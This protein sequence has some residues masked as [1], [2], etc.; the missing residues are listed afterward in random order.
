MKKL[1]IILLITFS[2]C[3]S[4][5]RDQIKLEK[6]NQRHPEVIAEKCSEIYIPIDSIIETIR[7][8]PGE[9]VYIDNFAEVNCDSMIKY[10]KDTNVTKKVKVKCPP[11]TI[12]R[13]SVFT[14]T[15]T[16]K[17][18]KAAIFL[19]QKSKDSLTKVSIEQKQ[20][21]K[22]KNKYLAILGSIFGLLILWT[23]FRNY[24]KTTLHI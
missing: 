22:V 9:T 13:D 8:V 3:I 19:L 4:L 5:R 20:K 15:E 6:I 18:N 10:V 21:I 7:Y 23:I 2:S 12:T 1:I 24:I 11:S 16:V 17:T 14:H